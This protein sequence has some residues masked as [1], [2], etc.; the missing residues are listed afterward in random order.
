MRSLLV[1]I[2]VIAQ[3]L[4]GPA[5]AQDRP[6][7]LPF[8]IGYPISGS[9]GDRLITNEALDRD[10]RRIGL[11]ASWHSF[12][13]GLMALRA[14]HADEIDIA[15]DIR[16]HEVILARLEELS[17]V[18]VAERRIRNDSDADQLF[19]DDEIRRYTLTS[20]YFADRREGALL[21][22]LRALQDAARSTVQSGTSSPGHLVKVTRSHVQRESEYE[23]NI[24]TRRRLSASQTLADKLWAF[25]HVPRRI[26]FADVNYWMPRPDLVPPSRTS[27]PDNR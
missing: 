3:L 10:L 27:R 18:F 24:A 25:G 12:E 19:P 22:I 11:I 8:R 1:A 17:M 26:D 5:F 21:L 6:L 14:L 16:Q 15:L 23:V 20:E 4:I 13:D 7:F 9:F 2:A